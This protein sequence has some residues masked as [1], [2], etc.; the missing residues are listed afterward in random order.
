MDASA[1]VAILV[2]EPEREAFLKVLQRGEPS[3]TSPIAVYEC[4]MALRRVLGCAIEQAETEVFAFLAAAGVEVVS[5]SPA[6]AHEALAAAARYGKGMGSPAQLNM[7]DCFAYAQARM[8]NAKM[9]F[10]GDDFSKTDIA[11]A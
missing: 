10:K 11:A 8:L 5:L 1:L 4:V 7:G 6:I 9:L 2:R 3:A